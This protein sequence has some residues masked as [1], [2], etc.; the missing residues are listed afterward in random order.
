MR[1]VA[2]T[3]VLV[4]AFLWTGPP[5]RLLTAAE[6]GRLTLYTSPVLIEELADVL[7]RRKFAPRLRALEVTVEELVVG[8]L[9]LARLLVPQPIPPVIKEDPED[10]HVLA[11]AL[12]AQASYLVTGD[13]HLLH[14]TSYRTV[15]IVSPRTFVSAVLR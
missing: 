1:V 13:P 7:A 4:S 14:L 15:P 10:D 12:A 6:R 11:C 2:D 3:N 8:Y 5:H 9:K